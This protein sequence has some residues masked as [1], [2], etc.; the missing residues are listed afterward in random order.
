VD[1]RAISRRRRLSSII[2]IRSNGFCVHS[3]NWTLDFANI[4]PIVWMMAKSKPPDRVPS[5]TADLARVVRERRAQLGVTQLE[6][7]AL[8]GCGV[9]FVYAVEN[10]KPSLRLDKLM[11]LLG[12]LGLGLE[13]VEGPAGL[14]ATAS[15]S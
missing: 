6:L 15:A 1:R 12:V 9:V 7:A 4:H 8:A 10:G 11:P 2:S 14:R 13:I 5:P 3:E